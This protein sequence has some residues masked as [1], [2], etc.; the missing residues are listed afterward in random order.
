[1]YRS[2][3]LLVGEHRDGAAASSSFSRSSS[4]SESADILCRQIVGL[5]RKQ[6]NFK[7]AERILAG[8]TTDSTHRKFFYSGYLSQCGCCVLT[9]YR[10]LRSNGLNSQ[11]K[12]LNS[13]FYRRVGSLRKGKDRI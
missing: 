6:Q 8:V 13:C 3:S 5:A 7:I 1:M 2:L 10:N 4:S 12:K 9:L 11:V